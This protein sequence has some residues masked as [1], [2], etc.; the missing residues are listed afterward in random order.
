[1]II[2]SA[3]THVVGDCLFGME[4]RYYGM[5]GQPGDEDQKVG[6]SS[7]HADFMS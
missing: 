6:R 2:Y 3:L 1:M 4:T 7:G 5:W